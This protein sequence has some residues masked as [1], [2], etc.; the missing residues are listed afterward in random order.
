L[1]ADTR[2]SP[3]RDASVRTLLALWPYALWG[4]ALLA[5]TRYAACHRDASSYGNAWTADRNG[6]C[7]NSGWDAL[8]AGPGNGSLLAFVLLAVTAA[9]PATVLAAAAL[10]AARRHDARLSRRVWPVVIGAGAALVVAFFLKW[11]H[12]TIVGGAGG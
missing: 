5:G 4:C 3:S 9:W 10:V 1:T 7:T 6:Y 8:T 2:G 11:G 12:V